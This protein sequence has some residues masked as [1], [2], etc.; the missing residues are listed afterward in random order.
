MDSEQ[1]ASVLERD[2]DHRVS[3]RVRLADDQVFA[4]NTTGE[5]CGRL[6]VIDTETTGLNVDLGDRIIDLA[7]ATCEYGRE[8][9]R[10]YRVVARYESLEDP[11]FPLAPEITRLTGITDDMVRGRR[12]DEAGIA[13]AL[14][15]VTLVVCHNAMF[16]RAFLEA[17]YPA[18]CDMHFACSLFEIPW[19][20]WGIGS[21]KL[22]YLGFSFGLFHDGH[23]ARTDVDML[24]A[25][26]DQSAPDG[27]KTL[28]A[29]LLDSAR[30]P[31]V[32]I[33]AIDLPYAS[34]DLAKAHGYRWH[35]GKFRTPQAWWIETRD[36]DGDREFLRQIG[37]RDPEVVRLTARERYRSFAVIADDRARAAAIA[38]QHEA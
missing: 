8:S 4:E 9:G 20:R 1:A 27:E 34:K 10:L 30:M 21:S 37:C 14:E 15:G 2:P 22:D 6:A 31:S 28:L 16:D 17:R 29:L 32:R 23:R 18:F 11:E 26:L 12:L 25:L 24:L 38:D 19:E 7:I 33:H 3:R 5:T 36:E 35:E 13:Q